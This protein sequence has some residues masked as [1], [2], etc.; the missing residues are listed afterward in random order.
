MFAP[1]VHGQPAEL[2]KMCEPEVFLIA[3]SVC[4]VYRLVLTNYAIPSEKGKNKKINIEHV[5]T[6]DFSILNRVIG[7][8]IG[9]D[10]KFL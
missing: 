7:P 1:F 4:A 9:I 5:V 8:A 2:Q 10:S 6:N 3:F